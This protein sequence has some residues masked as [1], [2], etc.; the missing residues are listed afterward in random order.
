MLSHA[1]ELLQNKASEKNQQ[2]VLDISRKPE[3]L[4]INREKMTRVISNLINNSIKFS[5]ANEEIHV[6][7]E[8]NNDGVIISVKDKGI[9][10]P[11][12]LAETVF[13]TFTPAKRPGTSGEKSFGLGL[14]ICRQIVEA[15]NG[16][17]WFESE[18]GMGTT[19]HVQL[20]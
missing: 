2:I 3:R 11:A 5:P 14:S 17:I 6:T 19:F 4:S 10:I 18:P 16:K 13:D 9:G 12:E 15:H 8:Q 7:A 20:N 1:V